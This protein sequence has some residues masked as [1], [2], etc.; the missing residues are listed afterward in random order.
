MSGYICS[1]ITVSTIGGILVSLLSDKSSKL[2]KQI[3]FIVGLICALV[4]I[5]PI[6][7]VLNNSQAIK[8]NITSIVLSIEG[9]HNNISNEI[10]VGTSLEKIAQGIKSMIVNKFDLN[11]QDVEVQVFVTDDSKDVIYI[12]YV[13]IRLKN[14]ATWIDDKKIEE[15]VQEMSGCKVQIKR[16]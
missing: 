10:I 9:E 6:I 3:G 16:L 4:F 7:G 8:D 15:Y 5:S 11:E 13:E 12:D 1:I 2:K 14:G